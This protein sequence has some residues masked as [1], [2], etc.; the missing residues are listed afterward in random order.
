MLQ[1]LQSAA[2]TAREMFAQRI[3]ATRRCRDHIEHMGFIVI[4]LLI[5]ATKLNRFTGQ[6]AVDKA[7]LTVRTTD[8]AAVVNQINNFAD[9]GSFI[10]HGGILCGR[11]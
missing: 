6:R 1:M 10:G 3:D 8:T 5:V 9:Q 11:I 2:A 7:C 4:A